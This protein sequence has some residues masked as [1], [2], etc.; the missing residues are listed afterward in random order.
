MDSWVFDLIDRHGYAGVA[1]LM[2]IET[3]FPPIPSE[4]I[5]TSAGVV[6]QR[7]D[8]TMAGTIA[9]GTIGA[10]LGNMLWFWLAIGLGRA[11]LAA[12]VERHGRWLTL[13]WRD[14]E[15]LEALFARFGGIIV[16][17]G[18]VLPNFRT[19]ISVPAG[20]FGMRALPFFLF[21]LVGTALWTTLLAGIGFGLAS[22]FAGAEQ[23]LG[24]I[25]NALLLL[26]LGVYVW[27]LATGKGRPPA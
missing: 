6:A 14:V 25:A 13:D 7:G 26:A 19:L 12:L 8:M 27:R 20:L 3:L 10:M 15:R 17:A 16:Q 4:V 24:P 18:R 23:V 9:A 21:S 2:L 1:S 22:R 11:R 5:M